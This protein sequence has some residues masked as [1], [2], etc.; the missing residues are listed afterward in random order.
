MLAKK[1]IEDDDD[2]DIVYRKIFTIEVTTSVDGDKPE[3]DLGAKYANVNKFQKA[4]NT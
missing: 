1:I 3:K 4:P 2:N